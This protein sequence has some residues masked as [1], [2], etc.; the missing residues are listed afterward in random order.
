MSTRKTTLFYAVLLAVASAAV[1]MVIASRLEMAPTSSAQTLAI[2]P[3]NSAPLNGAI[4]MGTFRDIARNQSPMVVNISTESTGRTRDLSDFFGGGGGQGDQGDDLFRRFFG[5]PDQP[6]TPQ[7]QRPRRPEMVR[8]AGTGFIISKE[9]FIL[10]N[11]HVVEGAS[12][13]VVKLY[14][15]SD[16]DEG[17]E[18]KLVGRDPLTDSALIELIEKPK[19]P[20]PEAKFGDSSQMAP[21]DWV[22]AIGNP[23]SLGHTVSVGVISAIGRPFAVAEGR[24]QN[25]L[26]TDAAINPGNSGGPLLN[27]RGEVVGMNTAIYANQSSAG[28]IGIGFAVPINTVRELLPQLRGGKVTRGLIGVSV[29]NVT[30]DEVEEFGLKGRQGALINT[31]AEH[32]PAEKAGVEPGDVVLEFNGKPVKNRD[33]LVQ[34]VTLTKPGTTVPIRVLRD[35]RER[36]LNITVDELNLEAEANRQSQS[37][38]P[39]ESAGFGLTL[40]NLTPETSRRLNIPRDVEGAVVTDIDPDGAAARARQPIAVGDVILQ[41]NRQ[42]VHNATEASRALQAVERGRSAMVLVW[43]GGQRVFLTIRKE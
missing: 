40:G 42:D 20:L 38:Q 21:G 8:A 6:Q 32:G 30:P 28:N 41:V 11:N 1:G 33:D 16:D 29:S 25:M 37:N 34:A 2:P 43:R 12:K 36:T 4:D 7:R 19:Q 18:A 22:M 27:L 31:V 9:G 35:R 15:E 26:Q 14:G 24:S 10:T 5:Q 39:D 23:F 3:M 13:I 17:F